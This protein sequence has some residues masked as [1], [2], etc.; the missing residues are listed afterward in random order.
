MGETLNYWMN[1]ADKLEQTTQ[2]ITAGSGKLAT[3]GASM[4]AAWS[5]A[6][7]TGQEFNEDILAGADAAAASLAEIGINV[8][9]VAP[10]SQIGISAALMGYQLAMK[11]A[12]EAMVTQGQMPFDEG[13]AT[14]NVRAFCAAIIEGVGKVITNAQLHGPISN[15]GAGFSVG[16]PM[17]HVVIIPFGDAKLNPLNQLK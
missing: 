16:S 7:D 1:V 15:A 12:A 6:A 5:G 3:G 4:I 17:F 2:T 10:A 13:R 14:G 9:S 11:G 8:P